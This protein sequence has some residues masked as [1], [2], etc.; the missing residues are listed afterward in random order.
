MTNEPITHNIAHVG[1]G[2]LIGAAGTGLGWLAGYLI[3][4]AIV[5]VLAASGFAYW[6]E[7][8]YDKNFSKRDFIEWVLGSL[9][10]VIAITLIRLA[11]S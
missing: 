5:G 1:F 8:S 2:A 3:L 7:H 6:K 10:G 4:G 9:L 11:T